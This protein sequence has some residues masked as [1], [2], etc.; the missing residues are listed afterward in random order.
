M[1]F[2]LFGLALYLTKPAQAQLTPPTPKPIVGARHPALSPDGQRLTFVYRGDIWLSDSKGGRARRFFITR[3]R[4]DR[5][6]GFER[7]FRGRRRRGHAAEDR[8]RSF[9]TSC[10]LAGL[11]RQQGVAVAAAAAR[12]MKITALGWNLAMEGA[13]LVQSPCTMKEWYKSVKERQ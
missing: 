9:G 8:P 2:L 7:G 1:R 5:R 3:G 10:G 11:V 12:M 4:R 6:S 13:V